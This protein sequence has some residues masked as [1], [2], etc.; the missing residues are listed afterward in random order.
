MNPVEPL[1][2]ENYADNRESTFS[3]PPAGRYTVRAPESFPAA[4]FGR[5]AKGDLSAQV[6][7]TI[8]APSHEGY[9]LRFTKVSA[10]PFQRGSVKVSQMG[11]YLRACGI[12]TRITDEQGLADAV[13]TT[14]NL[15]FEIDA[16]WRAYNKNTKFSV[17]GMSRFPSDG[18]GGHLPWYPDPTEKDESGEPVKLRANLVVSRYV[19][20]V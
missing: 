10:K 19:P 20:K 2:L 4:S 3:L 11:D 9:L 8:V 6:D 14:A 13:E 1:D 17:E 18:Q 7:P 16:E 15:L 5:T 12:R